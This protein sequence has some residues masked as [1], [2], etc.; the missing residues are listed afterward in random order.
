LINDLS[1]TSAHHPSHLEGQP[2]Q[3]PSTVKI[4]L[5]RR[6]GTVAAYTLIDPEHL[7]LVSRH[8]W[9]HAEDEHGYAW[10]QTNIIKNGRRTTLKLHH[11]IAGAPPP[12]HCVDHI[13]GDSLDNRRANLRVCTMAQNR[14]NQTKVRGKVG[15]RGVMSNGRRYRA[16]LTHE[17]VKYHLGTFDTPEQAAAAYNAKALELRGEYAALNPLPRHHLNA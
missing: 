6:D 3:V 17:G 2:Q 1:L 8:A 12:G 15:Y 7:P 14:Q 4:P 13:N 5:R 11:L 16:V 9:S 10:A